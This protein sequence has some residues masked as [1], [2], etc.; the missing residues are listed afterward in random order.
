MTT[1]EKDLAAF[2]QQHK[3]PAA[4]ANE[5][6]TSLT[7]EAFAMLAASPDKLSTTLQASLSSEAVAML[8]PFVLA[9]MKAAWSAALATF[10]SASSGQTS[11]A[12]ALDA[13]KSASDVASWSDTFPPKLSTAFTKQIITRFESA[14]PGD[15][16]GDSNTP[17]SRLLALCNKYLSDKCF[18]YIPWHLRLS[19]KT[20]EELSLHRPRKVPR[21]ED[22]LWD[23]VPQMFLFHL[24]ELVSIAYAMLEAAHLSSFRKYNKLFISLAFRRHQSDAGLRNPTVIELQQADRAAWKT[25]S[26]LCIRGWSLDDALHEVVEVRCILHSELQPRPAPPKAAINRSGSLLLQMQGARSWNFARVGIF[27]V[28]AIARIANSF[29]NAALTLMVSLACVTTRLTSTLEEATRSLG[30]LP[31]GRRCLSPLHPCIP[32]KCR[33]HL[34]N[35]SFQFLLRLS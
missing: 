13:S 27:A 30:R 34:R 26:D 35:R 8:N 5:L 6:A 21:L 24:L 28:D 22:L 18:K 32:L 23:D 20:Q 29:T 12:T 33:S 1:A 7:F 2:L 4:I 9:N 31:S 16:L 11:S 17:S 19:D 14:Y 3:V 25:I 15:I 10:A